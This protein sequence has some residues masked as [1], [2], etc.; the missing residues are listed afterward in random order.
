MVWTSEVQVFYTIVMPM[1]VVSSI[2][3]GIMLD[4]EAFL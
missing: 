1:L 2:V 4:V 3:T